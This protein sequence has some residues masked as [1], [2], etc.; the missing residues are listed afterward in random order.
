[1]EL[2]PTR[3]AAPGAIDVPQGLLLS[4]GLLDLLQHQVQLFGPSK[5]LLLSQVEALPQ[6]Q[7]LPLVDVHHISY[8]R[9]GAE[10][11]EDEEEQRKSRRV[12]RGG[13][14]QRNFCEES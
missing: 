2:A 12:K 9:G 4:N 8:M 5:V 11:G 6:R 3:Q 10:G 14:E 7:E 1:M 13:E